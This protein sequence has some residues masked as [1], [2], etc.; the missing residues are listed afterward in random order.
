MLVLEF[1]WLIEL[2]QS[3]K[4]MNTYEI[5]PVIFTHTWKI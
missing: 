5:L 2:T 1:A 4:D 3:D